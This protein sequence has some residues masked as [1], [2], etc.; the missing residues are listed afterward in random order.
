M[1]QNAA[2]LRAA[3]EWLRRERQRLEQYTQTQL[4]RIQS[5]RQALVTQTA[6]NEQMIIT[7]CQ[8]LSRKEELLARQSRT[9]QQQAPSWP[10]GSRR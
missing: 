5:D 9:L 4:D 6:R 8:E 7:G 3:N 10:S 2:D 1:I